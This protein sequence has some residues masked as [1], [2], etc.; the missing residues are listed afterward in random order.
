MG[1]AAASNTIEVEL[2]NGKKERKMEKTG[3]RQGPR[4][5]AERDVGSITSESE[6]LPEE[7]GRSLTTHV[8]RN[9]A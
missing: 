1:K 7:K 9:H 8:T 2:G 5:N 6:T 3:T 4:L